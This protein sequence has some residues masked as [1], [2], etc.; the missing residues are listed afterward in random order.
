MYTHETMRKVLVTGASGFVGANLVRRLLLDGHEV[1]VALREEH[2]HWRLQDL[3]RE[4]SIHT[5][6]IQDAAKLKKVFTAV[7]PSWIFHTAV[8]GAYSSQTNLTQMI[9]TNIQGTANLLTI[10]SEIGFDAFVNTGS[11]S[12]YGYTK[13]PPTEDSP[14][15][16]NSHY[17]ITKASATYLAQLTASTTG[18][19][20][21]T[22]RLYSVYGQYEEPTRLFPTLLAHA[23]RGTLPPLVGKKSAHD[24]VYIDD[25]VDAYILAAKTKLKERAA[26]F[27]IGS[28]KQTTMEEL[29]SLVRKKFN[30]HSQPQWGSMPAR[31]WDSTS[32]V[33]DPTKAHKVLKWQAKSTLVDG[34]QQTSTWLE[35]H[36]TFYK[37]SFPTQ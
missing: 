2:K 33:A 7:K 16:P 18:L 17:A 4:I 24:Y 27:N 21:P 37:K 13:S 26:I 35:Q 8:Y 6:D 9:A 11:S 28:G 29:V 23:Q 36:K 20:I 12:E 32:W 22:L 14:L 31:S 15:V 25:V 1:H 5:V 3:G 34:L 19:Q 10:A 30:I